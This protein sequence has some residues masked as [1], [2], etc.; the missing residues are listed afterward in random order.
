MTRSAKA[1]WNDYLFLTREMETFLTRQNMDMFYEL[2]RQR[3]RLQKMI[4]EQGDTRFA[5]SD[6]A[7]PMIGQIRTKNDFMA[8]HLR[9]LV[10]SS[11]K[12]QE[13][14]QAYDYPHYGPL[15]GGRVNQR[16]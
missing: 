1:L 15:V 14:N 7:K 8:K 11:K 9:L 10:N 16:G 3:D 6:E 13:V 5:A 2:M 4:G 12:R